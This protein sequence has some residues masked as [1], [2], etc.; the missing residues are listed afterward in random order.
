MRDRPPLTL[1]APAALL[2]IALWQFL[3]RARLYLRS[4]FSPDYGEGQVLAIIQ[5]M[6]LDGTFFGDLQRYPM[7]LSNY[8]PVYPLLNVPGFLLFGP[9]LFQPRLLSLLATLALAGFLFALLRRRTGNAWMSASFALLLF[10][11]WFVQT[12]AATARIDMLAQM[13]SIAGLYAFDRWGTGAGFR[14]DVP[15]WLFG[16]AFYTRQTTLVVPAAVLGAQLLEPARR[17]DVPRSLAAFAAPVLGVLLA[18]SLATR[19]QAWLHLFPYAAAADYDLAHMARCYG[20]FLLLASPLLLLVLAGLLRRPQAFLRGPNLPLTLFWPLSLAGLS[21]IAKEG[22]AQNYFIEPY[23]ATLLLAGIALGAL[24][25]SGELGPRS[26]PAAVFVAAAVVGLASRDLNRLPQAIRA[27]Q[28]ARAFIALDE[29]VRATEGPILSENLSAVVVNGKRAWTEPW[30]LM[31]L[32]KKGLWD[33]RVLVGDC[34]RGM[35]ALIVTETRLRE[36]P[37]ISECL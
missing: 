33:S 7:V 35:F 11:P 37:G 34:R 21:T 19:G 22:A 24:V 23:L 31:L 32:A 14:R 30:G 4:P 2:G 18:M 13:L 3:A 36:I 12:W 26:W 10:A 1:L 15:F 6:V 27:P 25:E 5:R 20:S 16:L 17:R 29:A 9:S 28:R 8:P